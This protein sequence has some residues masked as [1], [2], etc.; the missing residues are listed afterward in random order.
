MWS[1]NCLRS[2]FTVGGPPQSGYPLILDIWFTGLSSL[3][4][5]EPT[6]TQES[7]LQVIDTVADIISKHWDGES[8]YT[9]VCKPELRK[10]ES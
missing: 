4:S 9:D 7:A 2:G 6:V 1:I 5:L 10:T 8:V 3:E